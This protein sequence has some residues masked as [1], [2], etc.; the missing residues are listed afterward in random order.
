M[1]IVHGTHWIHN[2]YK[3]SGF[4]CADDTINLSVINSEECRGKI[5]AG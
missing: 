3:K 1:C 2:T 5:Q 4:Q